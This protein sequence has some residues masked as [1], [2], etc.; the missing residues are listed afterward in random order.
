MDDRLG[1][2]LLLPGDRRDRRRDARRPA[3]LRAGAAGG[4]RGGRA[5]VEGRRHVDGGDAA[6]EA[7]VR[8]LD[9]AFEPDQPRAAGGAG[10]LHD[11][12]RRDGARLLRAL[13]AQ[14]RRRLAAA[15]VGGGAAQR[16]F[17]A[18]VHRGRVLEAR[19]ARL[20]RRAHVAVGRGA[21][22]RLLVPR[23]RRRRRTRS[24][25]WGGFYPHALVQGWND[26]QKEPQKLGLVRSAPTPRPAAAAARA[27]TSA[28]SSPP[29]PSPS[30]ASP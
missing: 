20:G 29:S 16:E 7:L 21:H 3:L 8:P 12:A 30:S 17:E 28:V 14:Q 1:R 27:R 11:G 23:Q 6:G 4:V 9:L 5:G 25:G 13:R 10:E 26:G 18:H 15:R 22:V 2:R 24:W 19:P